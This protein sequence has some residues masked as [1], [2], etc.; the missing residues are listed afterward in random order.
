MISLV[1]LGLVSAALAQHDHD[2]D[3]GSPEGTPDCHC[4]N[5]LTPDDLDIACDDDEQLV[6]IQAYLVD[7]D[8]K[9]Y[10]ED[11]EI[12]FEEHDPELPAWRC[13]QMFSL[14]NQYHDYC[15]SGAINETLF[16]IYL[17]ECPDC[18]GETHYD[19]D[20]PDCDMTL[21]CTDGNAQLTAINYVVNNCIDTCE[22]NCTTVWQTVEGY[23]QICD[24]DD[25]SEEFDEIFD[26]LAYDETACGEDVHCNVVSNATTNCSSTANAYYLEHL[27]ELGNLTEDVIQDL[28]TDGVPQFVSGLGMVAS[29]FMML[30]Q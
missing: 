8:C 17:D 14:V 3:H 26:N 24:H 2:H 5:G 20:A 23:H 22:G 4:V 29:V 15:P 28:L 10:C 18:I 19:E 21:N 7:N 27:L 1:L 6:D 16:H 11:Q 30:W 25:L 13:F 9:G 12:H